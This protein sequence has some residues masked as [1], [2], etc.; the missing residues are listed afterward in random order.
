MAQNAKILRTTAQ[1]FSARFARRLHVASYFQ[2]CIKAV[3]KGEDGLADLIP[4]EFF[5]F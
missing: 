4:K 1:F 2:G 5:L 3:F